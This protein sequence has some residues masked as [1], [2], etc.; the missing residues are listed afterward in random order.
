MARENVSAAKKR[1]RQAGA[2]EPAAY[3]NGEHDFENLCRRDDV[4]L[5][6]TATPWDWHVPVAVSAM[7][8]GK[9][10]GVEV[11]AAT[12]IADCWK[13][14]DASEKTR[15][16]CMILENCCYG[17]NEMMVL[18]MVRSGLF[19]EIIHGEAAYIH[20]LRGILTEDRSEG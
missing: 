5:V 19:G 6:L 3:T 15:R 13:L 10:V 2:K 16:H 4:D 11:P 1:A 7:S 9:H 8:N 12:S 17:Y 18:N 20:D 14:V